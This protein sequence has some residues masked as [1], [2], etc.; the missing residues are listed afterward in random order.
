MSGYAAWYL[1]HQLGNVCMPAAIMYL[2]PHEFFHLCVV[3]VNEFRSGRELLPRPLGRVA[4]AG[5]L[6]V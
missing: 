2:L 6:V 3:S 1:S 4:P 5:G